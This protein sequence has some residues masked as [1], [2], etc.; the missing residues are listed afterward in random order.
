MSLAEDVNDGNRLQ[1]EK[2]RRNFSSCVRASL[3]KTDINGRGLFYLFE[4]RLNLPSD[5][6]L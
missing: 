5:V 3:R 1:L 4:M 2:F 6:Q